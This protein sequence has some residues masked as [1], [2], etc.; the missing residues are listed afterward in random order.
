MKL[1]SLLSFSSWAALSV[2]AQAAGYALEQQNAAAVGNAYAGAQAEIGDVGNVYNN[3]AVLGGIDGLQFSA[4][5]SAIFIDSSYSNAAGALL[6]LAPTP[7]LSADS[8]A[9]NDTILPSVFL[10]IR[11][12]D[13]V[14]LGFGLNAPF[15]LNSIYSN[16]SV[17]RYHAIETDLKAISFNA[18]AAVNLSPQLSVGGSLRVQRLDL[19]LEMR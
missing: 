5:A 12:N 10:G 3:P 4:N 8:G 15:G 16:G 18:A 13:A 11:V 14:S 7:G 17:V 2:S 1:A 6:G 19:T 9:L